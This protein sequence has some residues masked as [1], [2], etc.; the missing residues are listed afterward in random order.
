MCIKEKAVFSPC[1]KSHFAG[2]CHR[3]VTV[4]GSSWAAAP[5]LA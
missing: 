5:F 4:F 2:L 3:A 1:K